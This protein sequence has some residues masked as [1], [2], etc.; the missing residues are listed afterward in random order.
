MTQPRDFLNRPVRSLQTML[1][2]LSRI[3]PDIPEVLP[4]GIYG[5]STEAAVLAL[6]KSLDLPQTGLADRKTWNLLVSLYL[7]H[8]PRVLPPEPLSIIFEPMQTILPGE[9]NLHLYLMQ[10]MMQALAK[11]YENLPSPAVTGVY[12][13]Q[14]QRA[15]WAHQA[16]F[17]LAQNDAIDQIFWA[18]LAGLYTLAAGN[19]KLPS[20]QNLPAAQ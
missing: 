14:T 12:D 13:A 19:G 18:H 20:A 5:A 15:V 10:A 7:R 17:G 2:T 11:V 9:E 1:Q 8:A 16:V 4:D 6:Q 3:F